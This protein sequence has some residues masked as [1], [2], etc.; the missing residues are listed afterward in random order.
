[1][2]KIKESGGKDLLTI[3]NNYIQDKKGN[4]TIASSCLTILH[5]KDGKN[6]IEMPKKPIN[7]SFQ[8]FAKLLLHISH[9]VGK[10]LITF[11]RVSKNFRTEIEFSFQINKIFFQKM[12]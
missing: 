4:K 12:A 7:L 2:K 6:E 9:E 8:N 10:I 1:M 5:L 3:P 11:F